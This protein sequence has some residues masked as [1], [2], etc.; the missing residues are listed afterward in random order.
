M[1]IK[2]S[3]SKEGRLEHIIR[4]HKKFI[5]D[6]FIKSIKITLENPDEIILNESK[7]MT[8]IKLK[9]YVISNNVKRDFVVVLQSTKQ[10]KLKLVTAFVTDDDNYVSE[11]KKVKH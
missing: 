9:E 4:R 5:N 3:D 1:D 10:S 8:V 7:K 2:I 11:K 6:N